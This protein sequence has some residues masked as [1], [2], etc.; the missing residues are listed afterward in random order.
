MNPLTR[1]S[2]LL[3]LLL[4]FVSLSAGGARAEWPERP[5]RILVSYPA[6]GAND[7][8]A[9]VVAAR[10]TDALKQSFVVENRTGAAGSIAAEAAARAAPDG[11]TGLVYTTPSPRDS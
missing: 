3:L 6:G 5:V 9:R 4:G 8:V 2:V 10:L 11:E 7:Q 1:R